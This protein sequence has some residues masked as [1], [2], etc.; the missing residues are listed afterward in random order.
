M[1]TAPA[2]P[3]PVEIQDPDARRDMAVRF[4]RHAEEEFAKGNRLQASEKAWGAV[5][6]QLKAIAEQRGW[7]HEGHFRLYDIARYLDKE[8]KTEEHSPRIGSVVLA[9]DK[10]HRNF[11]ENDITEIQI[12]LAINEANEVVE[13]LE[14]LRHLDPRPYTISSQTEQAMV[15]RLTGTEYAYPT[16]RRFINQERLNER[17]AKWGKPPDEGDGHATDHPTPDQRPPRR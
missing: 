13:E 10:G 2:L 14:R 5:A 16:T 15:R 3:P 11:Y 17:R 8:Y 7:E 4:L 12:D 1:T 6:Q 9:L